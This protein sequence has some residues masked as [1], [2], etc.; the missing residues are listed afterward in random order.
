MCG[1]QCASSSPVVFSVPV[2]PYGLRGVRNSSP[3]HTSSA[4]NSSRALLCVPS[5][6]APQYL[7]QVHTTCPLGR[8]AEDLPVPRKSHSRGVRRGN[9]TGFELAIS[10]TLTLIIW[11]VKPVFTER[12]GFAFH[13]GMATAQQASLLETVLGQWYLRPG[14]IFG[15]DPPFTERPPNSILNAMWDC[16]Y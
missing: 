5:S 7:P 3:S 15:T 4:M 11:I 16:R 8:F 9:R 6:D 13:F 10:G 14:N 12:S 2:I 1:A